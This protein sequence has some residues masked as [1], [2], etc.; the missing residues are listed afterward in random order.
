MTNNESHKKIF[1][2]TAIESSVLSSSAHK[3]F[4][5]KEDL[6]RFREHLNT[7]FAQQMFKEVPYQ[8]KF[9]GAPD[10]RKANSVLSR[11]I[12]VQNSN[13]PKIEGIRKPNKMILESNVEGTP[14]IT[15]R[16]EH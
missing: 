5:S 9:I 10:E 2:Q 6:S 7:Q 11:S 13:L 12:E 16:L 14:D 15:D 4:Y 3:T 8:A 1:N